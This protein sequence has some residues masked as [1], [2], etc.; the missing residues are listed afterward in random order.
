MVGPKKLV[1]K[2]DDTGKMIYTYQVIP[3]TDSEDHRKVKMLRAHIIA[4]AIA[5]YAAFNID[6]KVGEEFQFS[7]K[8]YGKESYD[9]EHSLDAIAEIEYRIR[10]RSGHFSNLTAPDYSMFD[11]V[12]TVRKGIERYGRLYRV[13]LYLD[14]LQKAGIPTA[15]RARSIIGSIMGMV[16]TGD[17]SRLRSTLKEVTSSALKLLLVQDFAKYYKVD[18]NDYLQCAMDRVSNQGNRK[19][20]DERVC[21]NDFK[22]DWKKWDVLLKNACGRL[23]K[24]ADTEKT[25]KN[26]ACAR[27]N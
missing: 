12:P 3:L 26:V 18:A 17:V 20:K 8:K 19:T 25:G 15:R 5:R 13:S 16:S 1:E 9:A 23:K 14:A 6:G 27:E 24:I 7:L 4:T 11:P 22:E 10:K 2:E 21:G